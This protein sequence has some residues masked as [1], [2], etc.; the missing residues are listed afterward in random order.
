MAQQV[1][2]LDLVALGLPPFLPMPSLA[3]QL[4]LLP[5]LSFSRWGWL[6]MGLLLL[7]F[8]WEFSTPSSYIFGYLYTIPI[9]LTSVHLRR[10]QTGWV[11][12]A[13]IVLLLLNLWIPTHGLIDLP[14]L[15]NRLI[16][17]MAL[18]VTGI[19]SDRNRYYQEAL[20][21]QQHQIEASQTLLQL[22]EDF[23]LTL[24]HD[25]KTPLLGAIATLEAFQV[26]QFGPVNASQIQVIATMI[27]SHQ[28]SLQ[29]LATL[30]DIYRNDVD[31]LTL[32]LQPLD[33]TDLIEKTANTLLDLTEQ[34]RVHL[35]FR[36]GETGI[37]QSLWVRGDILQLQRVL[38]NLLINAINHSRRGDRIE[39][40]IE[41]E[42][43]AQV[44]KILDSGSGIAPEGFNDLFE[45]FYQAQ[46]SRQAKG[47]G[48]GLYLS[49]Q[50]ITAHGGIIWAENR[51]PQ[52][53][54]FGFKLP[55]TSITSSSILHVT[56]PNSLS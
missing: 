42:A 44:V 55:A 15:V 3:K 33:L 37:R 51:S 14:T 6:V 26:N 16:A 24:T 11:T 40:V 34:R 20:V 19:L 31:G 30:L 28:D 47:T 4:F 45:R 35:V 38:S 21:Q 13:G 32:N 48:L 46:T 50:I 43:T 22:R 9:I 1:V 52:G 23:T 29:L 5:P 7:I 36:Y 18:G 56:P 12:G 27:R 17:A 2:M 39:I 54:L 41:P 8:I 53:A 10:Q 25:L 49:R